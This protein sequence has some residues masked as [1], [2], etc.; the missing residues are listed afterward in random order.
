MKTRRSRSIKT[1]IVGRLPMLVPSHGDIFYLKL[2]LTQDHCKGLRSEEELRTV[3]GVVHSTC[4]DACKALGILEDDSEWDNCLSEIEIEVSP[5]RFRNIFAIIIIENSPSNV[6]QLFE[7]YH[8]R[9]IEDY[10]YSYQNQMNEI[11]TGDQCFAL[12]LFVMYQLIKDMGQCD[13]PD[14]RYMFPR[15]SEEHTNIAKEILQQI[16]SSPEGTNFREDNIDPDIIARSTTNYDDL[17]TEQK[18][19]CDDALGKILGD[20]NEQ[21]LGSLDAVAGTGKTFTLNVI[22]AKVLNEGKK[23][24]SAAFAGIA[25]T[26]LI[27]GSTFSSQTKAPQTPTEDMVLGVE[28]NTLLCKRIFES[29]VI[30]LD[31][32]SQF[33]KYYIEALDRLCQEIMGNNIVFGGKHVVIGSD[34]G[35]TLPIV[36]KA[37]QATQF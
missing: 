15:L 8:E 3:H 36:E 29:D 4:K 5:R 31:E 33:H 24:F 19:F 6:Q 1:E 17:N 37:S 27:G 35:Q 22:I 32:G 12:S 25:G 2:L 34:F 18:H 23:V 7:N 11:L 26:L 9:L 16:E 13:D 20:A 30:V 14:E 21:F 28:R 10:V